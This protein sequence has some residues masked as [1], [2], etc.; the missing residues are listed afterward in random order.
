MVLKKPYCFFK[1]ILAQQ[2]FGNPKFVV[3]YNI[4]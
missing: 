3:K 1:V 2:T 4:V